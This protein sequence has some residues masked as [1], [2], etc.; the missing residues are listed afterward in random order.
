MEYRATVTSKGQ[1]TVPK[2]VRRAMGIKEG[3]SLLFDLEDGDVRLRV[4]RKPVSFADYAGAWRVGK[5]MSWEEV[6]AYVRDLR[7][8][9]DREEDP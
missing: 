8:R 4:E 5:G 1:V 7:G 6:N 3:D 2:A 9:D